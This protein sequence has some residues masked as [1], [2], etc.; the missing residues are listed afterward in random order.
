M[1]AKSFD[2]RLPNYSSLGKEKT[3]NKV[4]NAFSFGKMF[5]I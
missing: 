3:L 5:V 2:L 1:E 4:E